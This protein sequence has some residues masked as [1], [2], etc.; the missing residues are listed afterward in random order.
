MQFDRLY[1][2]FISDILQILIIFLV[3]Y[4]IVKTIKDTRAWILAKGIAI[5]FIIY[6]LTGFLKLNG[7]KYILE[8]S[9]QLLGIAVIIMFQPELQKLFETIGKQDFKTWYNKIRAA[10]ENVELEGFITTKAINEIATACDAMSKVKTGVLIVIEGDTPLT[11]II[12]SGIDI[13]ADITSE[14]LINIFE[15]NTPLHDGAVVIKDNKVRAATCYLPLTKNS[16]V[17]KSLG[18]RHRAGIGISEVT[19][20]MV[21]IV[22]EETGEISTC[23]NG[24][25]SHG[26]TSEKLRKLLHVFQEN[27]ASEKQELEETRRLKVNPNKLITKLTVAFISIL[28][29]VSLANA[30]DSVVSVTVKDV[31]VQLKNESAIELIGQTYEIKSGDTVD[32]TIT[33]RKSVVNN[34]KESDIKA[35][36]DLRKLSQVNSVPIEVSTSKKD[37]EVSTKN[38]DVMILELE[39]I[40]EKEI[41]VEISLYGNYG[42]DKYFAVDSISEDEIRVSAPESRIKDISKAVI[43]VDVHGRT[44]DFVTF[45]TPELVGENGEAVNTN[46]VISTTHQ[47]K[48]EAKAYNRKEVTVSV[49]LI[50]DKD[51]SYYRLNNYELS[52]N[53][54]TIAGEQEAL[55]GIDDIIVNMSLSDSNNNTSIIDISKYVSDEFYI[56]D[57]DV[58]IT[59]K[60]DATKFVKRTIQIDNDK[61]QVEYNSALNK[62]NDL[63]IISDNCYI[64]IMK[65]VEL[66]EITVDMLAPTLVVKNTNIGTY[67]ENLEFKSIDGV[68]IVKPAE[69]EYRIY[70]K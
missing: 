16:E 36:A 48:V 65:D 52:K 59:I 21:V 39:D 53:T 10:R 2:F 32:V 30:N 28:L 56:V 4:Y 29:W 60:V 66:E 24:K 49:N 5:V 20:A 41:P 45:C 55:D 12:D 17:D 23:R 1:T 44:E 62:K 46:G 70:K 8:Q 50:N 13:N 18:T 69:V 7:V 43:T 42:N 27:S 9:M 19:D 15:K 34:I 33:G 47:I 38:S 64:E 57:E 54:I 26:I 51:D 67:S 58:N 68:E 11:S 61:I 31:P 3:L 37:I 22:S 6:A 25:I 63:G 14:L 40:V 35:F